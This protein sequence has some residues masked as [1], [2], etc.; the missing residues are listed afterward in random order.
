MNTGKLAPAAN[1]GFIPALMTVEEVAEQLRIGRSSAYTLVKTRQIRTIRIGRSI[2]IP[3]NAIL[4][5]IEGA[6]IG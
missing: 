3:R 1:C 5:F 4:E 2:R 6:Q